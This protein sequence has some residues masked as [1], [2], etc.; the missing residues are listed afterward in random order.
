MRIER[1]EQQEKLRL[2]CTFEIF[3]MIYCNLGVYSICLLNC[4]KARL[5][6]STLV[7]LERLCFEVDYVSR[8]TMYRVI[9]VCEM[10]QN[11]NFKFFQVFSKTKK[12]FA[13]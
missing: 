3:S 11:R 9:T 4:S 13:D 10:E 7:F 2:T 5:P 6:F 8:A 12:S 1:S